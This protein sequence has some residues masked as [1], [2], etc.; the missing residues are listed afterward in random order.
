M[1][2]LQWQRKLKNLAANDQNAAGFWNLCSIP[3]AAA[4]LKTIY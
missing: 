2:Y 4:E 1:S 3:V